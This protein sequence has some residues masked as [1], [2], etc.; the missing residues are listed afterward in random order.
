M[1]LNEHFDE[2]SIE[3]VDERIDAERALAGLSAREAWALYWWVTDHTQEEIGARMG[4]DQS[5]ISRLLANLHKT[6]KKW[7][8][9]F[10][11]TIL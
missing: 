11:D 5:T 1:E 3:S 2:S 6:P 9:N 8:V 4:C 7:R 10:R